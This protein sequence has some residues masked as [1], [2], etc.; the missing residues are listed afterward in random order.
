MQK[1]RNSYFHYYAQYEIIPRAS[2]G[3]RGMQLLCI[4]AK[5][6]F[7]N[8]AKVA[9]IVAKQQN[10]KQNKSILIAKKHRHY[11]QY[12]F[13]LVV[14][15]RWQK[16]QYRSRKRPIFLQNYKK[17]YQHKNIFTQRVCHVNTFKIVSIY[18][19]QAKLN[20]KEETK[21]RGFIYLILSAFQS[22]FETKHLYQKIY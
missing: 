15:F 9:N 5:V 21:Q 8:S 20:M 16:H 3:R 12:D 2:A 10:I 13:I 4:I 1:A 18:E 11:L 22:I 14:Y 7:C 6:S 19:I 17:I